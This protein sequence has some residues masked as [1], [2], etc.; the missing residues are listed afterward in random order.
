M[1]ERWLEGTWQDLE[2]WIR[3]TIGS[4]FRWRIRPRDT[5]PN[6]RMLTNLILNDIKRNGGVFPE[7]N[8]FIERP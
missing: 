6:R 2:A 8:A 3:E 4:D 1:D 7:S 5:R